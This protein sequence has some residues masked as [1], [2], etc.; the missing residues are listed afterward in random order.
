VKLTTSLLAAAALA[1]ATGATAQTAAQ[2]GPAQSSPVA[3]EPGA[4]TRAYFDLWFRRCDAAALQALLAPDVEI[5]NNGAASFTSDEEMGFYAER[6][7]EPDFGTPAYRDL[8]EEI[9]GTARAMPLK[10]FGVLESGEH[11]FV[12]RG[13]DGARHELARTRY[14]ALWKKA[15]GGWQLKRLYNYDAVLPPTP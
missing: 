12:R 10:D 1:L 13:P 3:A 11:R 5:I 7:R 9:P 15:P 14:L 6:C 8:R 2:P 4:R